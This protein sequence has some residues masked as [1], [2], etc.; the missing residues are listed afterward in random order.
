[1]MDNSCLIILPT[2]IIVGIIL[3][4]EC[5]R[6]CGHSVLAVA[7]PRILREMVGVQHL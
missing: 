4:D 5:C 3:V 2:G 6:H 1:M 7:G